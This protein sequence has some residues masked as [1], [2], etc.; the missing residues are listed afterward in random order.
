MEQRQT[1]DSLKV[2]E[3]I[4]LTAG[5]YGAEAFKGFFAGVK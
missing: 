5:A 3:I 4:A 1:P 2:S